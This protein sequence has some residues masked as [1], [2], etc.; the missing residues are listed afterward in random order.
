MG[1][2]LKKAVKGDLR[3]NDKKGIRRCKDDFMFDLK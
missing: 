3:R 2:V 1:R